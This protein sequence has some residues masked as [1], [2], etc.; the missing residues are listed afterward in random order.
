MAT[1][2]YYVKGKKNPSPIYLRLAEGKAIDLWEKTGVYVNP[3]YWEVQKQQVR[4][5]LDV[6]N[7]DEI[8]SNLKKLE[9]FVNDEFNSA[10]MNGGIINKIW[11]TNTVKKFFNRPKEE[12]KLVNH[13]RNIY[14]TDYAQYWIDNKAKHHKVSSSKYMDSTTISHYQQVVDNIVKFQ[15]K[16]KILL[17]DIT[18]ELLDRFSNF[19]SITEGYAHA[20]TKR[21][22]NR[23]KFFCER[24]DSDNLEVN[25]NFKN[26]VFVAKEATK[27]KQPYLNEDEILK[28]YKHDFS[29]NDTL[30]NV[31]DNL[32][33]GLWTSLR[34]SDYLTRLSVSNINDG[35]IEITPSKTQEYG[36]NVSIPIHWMVQKILD[37]RNGQLPSKISEQK[38]NHY[39]KIIAQ[40]AELDNEMVGGIVEVNEK[41]KKA[42]KV[43]GVYKKYLLI[44][45]HVARR[46][47]VTN[48]IGKI[49]NN[50]LMKICGWTNE[51]QMLEYVKTT[52]RESAN[53]LKKY[54]EKQT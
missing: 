17:K 29:Y 8:N 42:R 47:F 4:K 40:I 9:S 46:S 27:Y 32:I 37:K 16:N 31:R 48:L 15:G 30:D 25:K 22:I 26:T 6:A 11:L 3:D 50:D 33:I 18:S 19:L 51:R 43:I 7:R 5:V 10:Y 39:I 28:I 36:I 35:F 54:W 41:T 53:V 34:V 21:K 49:P 13:D 2:N 44:T 20:T 12:D 45:S 52:N 24:A 23:L 14:L 38:F 1:I